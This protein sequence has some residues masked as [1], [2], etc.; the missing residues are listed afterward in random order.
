[1]DN[2][3]DEVQSLIKRIES[4]PHEY[5][6]LQVFISRKTH[7]EIQ[8][9]NEFLMVTPRGF[10]KVRVLDLKV[11]GENIDIE[12]YDC[13]LQQVGDIRINVDDDKPLTFF[14]RWQDVKNMVLDETQTL[15]NDEIL[16]FDF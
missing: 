10:S 6:H 2:N 1:M 5:K 14:V 11:V 8:T 4:S 15:D 13:T 3:N 9:D 7:N 12:L 16:E